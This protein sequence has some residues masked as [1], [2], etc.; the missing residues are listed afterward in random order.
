LL[1]VEAASWFGSIAVPV[2]AAIGEIA[3]LARLI[4][5]VI[6]LYRARVNAEGR[7]W[8]Q[9]WSPR[10]AV[11]VWFFPLGNLW[12]PFQIMADIWRAGLPPQA[13][14]NRA[15]I[16]GCWLALPFASGGYDARA[17]RSTVR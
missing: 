1:T 13:R 14:R 7:G 10:W 6:W 8:A 4:V 9:R 11:G 16:P 15:V 5:F 3:F 2:L 12:Y 17:V